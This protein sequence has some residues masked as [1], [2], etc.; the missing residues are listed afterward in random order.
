M[1]SK[2]ISFS[3]AQLN[4]HNVNS[5]TVPITFVSSG[6]VGGAQYRDLYPRSLYF[7]NGTG[8]SIS[9]GLLDN[10]TQA[11]EYN[12]SSTNFDLI[13]V[14][15]GDAWVYTNINPLPHTKYVIVQC[16]SGST[17]AALDMYFLNFA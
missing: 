15:N 1:Y 2:K 12:V 5:G 10:D 13:P 11:A 16:P 14:A 6:L 9:F 7:K 17:S 8:Q 3:T 4:A